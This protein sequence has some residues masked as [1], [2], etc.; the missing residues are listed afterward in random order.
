V[1]ARPKGTLRGISTRRDRT[2]L[3]DPFEA[4]SPAVMQQGKLILSVWRR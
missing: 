4:R 1:T 3:T 2:I